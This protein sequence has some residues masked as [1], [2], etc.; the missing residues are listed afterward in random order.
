MPQNVLDCQIS[1]PLAKDAAFWGGVGHDVD[2]SFFFLL[3]IFLAQPVTGKILDNS[4]SAYLTKEGKTEIQI[5][6]INIPC[7]RMYAYMITNKY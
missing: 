3:Q 6:R 4:H 5:G 7:F 2:L 1:P